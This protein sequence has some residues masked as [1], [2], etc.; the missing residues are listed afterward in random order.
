MPFPVGMF[1]WEPNA[2]V[3]HTSRVL[4]VSEGGA[5]DTD[6]QSNYHIYRW[7]AFDSLDIG[8]TIWQVGTFWNP[9]LKLVVATRSG[10]GA[11]ALS[12]CDGAGGR[13]D[14]TRSENDNHNNGNCALDSDG[15]IH[16]AY[17]H[18]NVA[19]N[20]RRS[21]NAIATF[22]GTFTVELS[23]VGTNETAV[24]YPTFFRDPLGTLYFMFRNGA[25]GSGD[26][27]AFIYVYN[28]GSETWAGLG[29]LTAGKLIDGVNSTPDESPY[30]HGPPEFTSNW[31]GA[32]TGFMYV[33][34][35]WR[36]TGDAQTMHDISLVRWNG[37]TGWTK[38]GGS[39]QTVPITHENADIVDPFA[40]NLDL[41]SFNSMVLDSSNRPHLFH[42]GDDSADSDRSKLWHTWYDGAT[43]QLDI[44][45][46]DASTNFGLNGPDAVI[47][48]DDTIRVIVC[49]P[50]GVGNGVGIY[51][52]VSDGSDWDTWALHTLLQ[53]DTTYV[54]GS[55]GTN[56]GGHH[57]RRMWEEEGI[58]RM[59]VPFRGQWA[60][61][62]DDPADWTGYIEA[63]AD[64][65]S[66]IVN[67]VILKIAIDNTNT[68]FWLRVASDGKDIRAFD[69]TGQQFP[70]DLVEFN[71]AGQYALLHVLRYGEIV[72]APTIRIYAGN[73]GASAPADGDT[74]GREAVY[75]PWC[76]GCWP[77]GGGTDRT[78]FDN[79]FTMTGSPTTTAATGPMGETT[80]AYDGSTQHGL[81][82]ASIPT[83]TN[84]RETTLMGRANPDAVTAAMS[85]LG[86]AAGGLTNVY[87]LIYVRGD[88]ALDP[89]GYQPRNTTALD[90]N[91]GSFTAG[92]WGHVAGVS[93]AAANHNCYMDGT[94]GTPNTNSADGGAYTRLGVATR[95]SSALDLKFD[96]RLAGLEFHTIALSSAYI[97]Y[98]SAQGNQ[99]TFYNGWAW[100]SNGGIAALP[101]IGGGLIGGGLIGRSLA[102]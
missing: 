98:E 90:I 26:A 69:E 60:R 70:V 83:S 12:T 3:G 9:S 62:V 91:I 38:I 95:P 28:T 19:L 27:D 41:T 10:S 59:M 88:V 66:A 20:Y 5:T 54:E 85:V 1:E 71:Y 101:I 2:L 97:A 74:F 31:D 55:N 18:H 8:G 42:T 57:D 81:A 50:T 87:K 22:D 29:G 61:T 102:I 25:G 96:G 34:W 73:A 45:A 16:L 14:I 92:V 17:D 36:D 86:I 80:Y 23:M 94:A 32:G 82:T 72:T 77:S 56:V 65:P 13:P 4:L 11:W 58:Y 24:A 52:Y 46:G 100:V 76:R 44:I 99:A 84:A 37:T 39:S 49:H 64:A 89:G 33:A 7:N 43:W 51:A 63:T 47:D 35:A 40:Q 67:D 75:P 6:N 21:V 68:Q 93:T 48:D 79:D 30:W 53:R 15:I 78:G